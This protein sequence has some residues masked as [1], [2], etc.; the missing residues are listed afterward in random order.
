MNTIKL[1]TAAAVATFT[2]RFEAL[3]ALDELDILER[4]AIARNQA[5]IQA[6]AQTMAWI[7]GE[8]NKEPRTKGLISLAKAVAAR[9]SAQTD[10]EGA[11]PAIQAAMDDLRGRLAA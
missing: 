7:R 2:P 10:L 5:A 9:R 8:R 1:T 3:N 6:C 4:A 11:M